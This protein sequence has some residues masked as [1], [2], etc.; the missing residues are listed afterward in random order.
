MLAHALQA[1]LPFMKWT[2]EPLTDDS[3]ACQICT[4]VNAFPPDRAYLSV[5]G[6]KDCPGIPERIPLDNLARS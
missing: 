5:F 4:H 6:T 1:I 2:L 3:S